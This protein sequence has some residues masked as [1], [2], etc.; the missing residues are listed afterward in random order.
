M[1]INLKKNE[2][3]LREIGEQ[4]QEFVRFVYKHL[5]NL[6][7]HIYYTK[8]EQYSIGECEEGIEIKFDRNLSKT[9]NLY[10]ETHE[11]TKYGKYIESGVLREDNS[12]KY[13]IGNYKYLFLFDKRV[14]KK[15]II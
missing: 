1:E 13:L 7:L 9:N 5:Y 12:I 11:K 6:N 3:T 14:L 8:D 10:I 2:I 4:Y 15:Y